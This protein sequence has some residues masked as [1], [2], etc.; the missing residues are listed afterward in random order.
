MAN[1]RFKP[2]KRGIGA[3]LKD[4]DVVRFVKKIADDT[5]A[6]AAGWVGPVNGYPTPVVKRISAPFESGDVAI[7]G[8][9]PRQDI[10]NPAMWRNDEMGK[11]RFRATITYSHPTPLGRKRSRVALQAA[12]AMAVEFKSDVEI[13]RDKAE[14]KAERKARREARLTPEQRAA[15]ANKAAAKAKAR[16]DAK[17]KRATPEYKA[18]QKAKRKAAAAKRKAD[19]VYQA[20]LK[21][22][23]AAAKRSAASK[24]GWETRRAK[25]GT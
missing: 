11:R 2:D 24:K 1:L 19:P 3:L 7:G 16:A 18:A 23:R 13:A 21:A 25:K 22:K 17:A 14:K 5:A 6:K 10:G 12:T 4:P 8:L 20:R 15:R 9:D